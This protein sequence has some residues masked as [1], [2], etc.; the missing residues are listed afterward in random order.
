MLILAGWGTLDRYESQLRRDLTALAVAL[1]DSNQLTGCLA[2]LPSGEEDRW[3]LFTF[4]AS[5]RSAGAHHTAAMVLGSSMSQRDLQ[6][7]EIAQ[8][9]EIVIVQDRAD[10]TD[11]MTTVRDHRSGFPE[12][13]TGVRVWL[14]NSALSGLHASL[15]AWMRAMPSVLSV[16][17]APFPFP[18]RERDGAETE[19]AGAEAVACE[20]LRSTITVLGPGAIVPCPDFGAPPISE[21]MAIAVE[22]PRRHEEWLASLGAHP[23]CSSCHRLARFYVPTWLASRPGNPQL[24]APPPATLQRDNSVCGN[25]AGMESAEQDSLQAEFV[26]RLCVRLDRSAGSGEI[27]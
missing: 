22:I 9:N 26:K 2:Q 8:L 10:P 20:W 19:Q 21:P 5:L 24:I 25:L 3:W 16:E 13:Q 4:L 17:L 6:D 11:M 1:R 15:N 27:A 12:S 14:A 23:Q 7:C 18:V